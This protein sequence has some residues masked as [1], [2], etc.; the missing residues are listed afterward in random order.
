MN[1][2]NTYPVRNNRNRGD[3]FSIRQIGVCQKNHGPQNS[4]WII[5]QPSLE[6]LTRLKLMIDKPDFLS[7][8]EEDPMSLHLV[9]IDFQSINWDDFIEEL[10]ISLEPLVDAAHF[11]RVGR[12]CKYPLSDYSVEFEQCQ[13]LQ[14][15]QWKLSQILPAIEG[16]IAALRTCEERWLEKRNGPRIRASI[17]DV[18]GFIKQLEFHKE[19]IQ[20]LAAQAQRSAELLH[21]ILDFRTSKEMQK[22][23]TN[24]FN[25]LST[26]DSQ[27]KVL[28]LLSEQRDK[29]S[30][31]IKA[32]TSVATFYLPASL[33][34]AIFS[35]NLVQLLPSHEPNHFVAAPQTWIPVTVTLSLMAV[36]LVSIQLL[37][38][39]YRCLK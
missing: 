38:R 29:D 15:F 17:V 28:T 16:N 6:V 19:S 36:T 22:T 26:L 23:N 4:T 39:L 37:E 34:A 14:K 31:T 32:L 9:F 18:R 24:M 33:V 5:I 20:K 1:A 11:S 21:K 30:K 3:P 8:H 25:T 10:R 35:S 7:V 2:T 12:S 27:A 13:N